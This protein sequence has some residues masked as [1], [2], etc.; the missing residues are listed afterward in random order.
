[1]DLYNL[2]ENEFDAQISCANYQSKPDNFKL[3]QKEI[4]KPREA[5]LSNQA[6]KF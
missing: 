6:N 4:K 2:A 3:N 1:M 5:I